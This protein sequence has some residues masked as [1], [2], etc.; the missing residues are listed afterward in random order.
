MKIFENYLILV[1]VFYV[2]LLHIS[3][4]SSTYYVFLIVNVYTIKN[5]RFI[6]TRYAFL[7]DDS[8]KLI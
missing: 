5:G 6:M 3:L 2:D 7:Q 4:V 8:L 1:Y